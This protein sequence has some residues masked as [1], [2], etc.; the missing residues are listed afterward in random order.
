M[1]KHTHK[2]LDQ[3]KN[4]Y[5]NFHLYN[6]NRISNILLRH[7][8]YNKKCYFRDKNGILYKFFFIFLLKH[9]I[10]RNIIEKFIG[11][12]FTSRVIYYTQTQS[13]LYN[14]DHQNSKYNGIHMSIRHIYK[15]KNGSNE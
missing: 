11:I 2:F 14:V 5:L 8:R 3:K 13:D 7:Y 15:Y 9:C 4:F 1:K 6:P 12:P 10:P